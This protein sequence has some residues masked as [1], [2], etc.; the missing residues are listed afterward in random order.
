M[1]ILDALAAPCS[2]ADFARLIGRSE[3]R[4]SQLLAEGTLTPGASAL[5]W[6]QAYVDRLSAEAAGRASDGPLD[7]AQERAALA[8]AQRALIEDKLAVNRGEYAPVLLLAQTLAAASQ[9]VA[10]RFDHLPGRV[11]RAVPGLP[12][13]A[14]DQV[15]AVIAEAR[16]EWVA[17]T[18]ALL[19][20][21]IADTDSDDV[22]PEDEP[23]A[24]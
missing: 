15:L 17:Q 4:V 13:S 21:R 10:E 18:V 5:Q 12:S 23:R 16:T 22:E 6:L 1:V 20:A 8:R 2:Q 19:S 9:A 3:G 24:D 7:L 14:L 11:R